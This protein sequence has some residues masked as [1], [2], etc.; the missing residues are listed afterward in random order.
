MY[1]GFNIK[2]LYV[3]PTHCIY[4]SCMDLRKKQRLFRYATQLSGFYIRDRVCLL[5]GTNWIFKYS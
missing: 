3:L 4:V 1:M 5:R 2:N